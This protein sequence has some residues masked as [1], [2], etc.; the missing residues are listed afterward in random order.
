VSTESS[1]SQ[2]GTAIVAVV[3]I[4]AIAIIIAV[5]NYKKTGIAR[6][7]SESDIQEELG[8]HLDE[9]KSTLTRL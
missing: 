5:L 4:A 9:E 1:G 3:A 6:W 2:K 7:C 8:I